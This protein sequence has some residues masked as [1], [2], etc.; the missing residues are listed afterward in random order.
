VVSSWGGILSKAR[1]NLTTKH[2]HVSSLV[3]HKSAV[4]I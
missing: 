2:K 3:S 4:E 1:A